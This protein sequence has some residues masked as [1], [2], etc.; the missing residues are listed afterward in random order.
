[1]KIRYAVPALVAAV[2]LSLTGC[3]NNEGGSS[4]SGSASGVTADKAA[5]ALL[6]DDVKESGKL[7]IG[8]D[9]AYP[10]NEY[11][12]EDGNPTGWSVELTDALAAKLGLTPKWEQMGFDSIL[13]R[14]EEG[15]LNIGSSSFSDTLERQKT[16]DFVNY[17]VGGSQWASAKG[18]TIDPDN[19][20]GLTIAVQSGTVQYTDELPARSEKCVAE[21]KA[22]IE[23]LPFDDQVD[24][25][26]AVVQGRA[27]AFSAD[28][29]VT[30]DA[31]K[32]RSE[33]LQLAGKLFNGDNYGFATQKGSKMT[34]AVQAAL[35]SLIDDGTY[36]KILTAGGVDSGAVTTATINAGPPA[37]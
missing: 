23:I 28:S 14:I 19:A 11:L 8:S 32:K 17:L 2:A 20:C 13:P 7:T 12:D 37:A 26:E 36:L 16:V 27:A 34:K 15:D 25:A 10:P 35:Q 29:F 6:P 24:A 18:E 33:E 21:G 3:V 5:V 4:D 31:V 22:A 9:L 1:M 30:A